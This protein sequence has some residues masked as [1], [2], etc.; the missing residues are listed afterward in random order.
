[1]N[2]YAK[3]EELVGMT[4]KEIVGTV[5]DEQLEFVTMDGARFQMLHEQDCCE[6]VTIEDITGDLNDL[7]G[8]PI[9]QAEESSNQDNPRGNPD[10]SWTW[11]FYRIATIKGSVVIRWYGSSNGYYSESVSFVRVPA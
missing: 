2:N 9:L 3:F 11:T 7:I 10:E 4:L 1:M 8:S 6:S 5:N